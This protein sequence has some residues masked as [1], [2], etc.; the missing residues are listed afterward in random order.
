MSQSFYF[1]LSPI[2][3]FIEQSRRTRDFWAGS[4]LVSW[5]TGVAIQAVKQ[6]QGEMVFPLESEKLT[7]CLLKPYNKKNTYPRQGSIPSCFE[8][9]IDPNNFNPQLVDESVKQAWKALALLVYNN[10]IDIKIIDE[11]QRQ[12]TKEIWDKQVKNFWQVQWGIAES[13]NKTFLDQRKFWNIYKPPEEAGIKC[14]IMAGW[15]ELS[16]ISKPNKNTRKKSEKFWNNI[17]NGK[18][19]ALKTDMRK[20]EALCAIA[21]IKRRFVHYFKDLD[22]SNMPANWH[23]YGWELSAGVPSVSYLAGVHWLE[24]IIK[25]AKESP[26][27]AKALQRFEQEAYQL[28]KSRSAWDTDI[29]CIQEL[30]KDRE[31][32]RWVSHD[33]DIFFEPLL[34]N[35]N[36]YD[37][38][39]QAKEVINALNKLNKVAK[40]E[41]ASS[42]YAILRMD[43]DNMSQQNNIAEGLAKFNNQTPDIVKQHNGFLI[44]AGG[45]D[46]LA[47]L[48]LEDAIICAKALY[49]C[50]K[51]VIKTTNLS[52]A[53]EYVHIKMPLAS[54]LKDS[55]D[56]LDKIAKEKMGRNAL[57]IRVWK[58]GGNT[59][60]WAKK[61]S[62]LTKYLFPLIEQFQQSEKSLFSSQ[63]FYHLQDT[64]NQLNS[65]KAG[66]ITEHIDEMIIKLVAVAYQSSQQQKISIKE[67]ESITHHLVQLC[68]QDSK[69]LN[70][71]LDAAFFVRFLAH[72]G[73]E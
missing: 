39:A 6:Q 9:I 60:Q 26:E 40:I 64:F 54:V 37:D 16:G 27:I 31:T 5:L 70:F 1:F 11:K 58:T 47:L 12:I 65:T 13:N 56:L 17:R 3:S 59:L 18:S 2:Q 62:D 57:A 25:G 63:F 19:T 55:H 28:T 68:Y 35:K 43:G 32:K 36:N 24:Q 4:F 71:D 21:F 44:Y 7:D 34:A 29:Q 61:W 15:Q 50:F 41:K 66:K 46:V 30:V 20:K 72:K 53:I 52:G 38:Q 23:L 67:A 51:K 73:V 42:F 8:A 14:D 10:D 49:D 48:P 33:G 45:D 69:K 22:Y